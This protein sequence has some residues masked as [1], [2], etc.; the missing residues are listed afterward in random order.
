MEIPNLV[1]WFSRC[2]KSMFNYDVQLSRGI[3]DYTIILGVSHTQL[4]H[5][6]GKLWQIFLAISH[7][8]PGVSFQAAVDRSAV[9]KSHYFGGH[10]PSGK[11]T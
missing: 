9:W 4:G 8:L 10:I 7:L 1:R 11:L 5:N 2:I 3:P 6:H